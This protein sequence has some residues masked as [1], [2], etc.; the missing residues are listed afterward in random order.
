MTTRGKPPKSIDAD[1]E[2]PRLS[3]AGTLE[4]VEDHLPRTLVSPRAYERVKKAAAQLPAALSRQIYLECRLAEHSRQVDLIVGVERDGARVLAGHHPS[5]HLAES[6]R[7]IP[8]W[9]RLRGFCREWLTRG[10]TLDAG[11]ER[12]WLEL[13]LDARAGTPEEGTLDPGIFVNFSPDAL[14][15]PPWEHRLEL[16]L[17]SVSRLADEETR[18]VAGALERCF[19]SLPPEASPT[20]VG[21]F[22]A[23]WRRAVRV[24]VRG[25]WG[26]SAADFLES[27]GWPRRRV[28]WV[29]HCLGATAPKDGAQP[30]LLHVEV[31]E[32]PKPALGLEFA[33]S[34]PSQLR[35][36][37]SEQGWLDGL[38]RGHLCAPRK[39]LGLE[40]WPGRSVQT[41]RH[42][43]WPSLVTRWVNHV[44][45]VLA[46]GRPV[47]AKAY[48]Y[49]RHD[50]EPRL[51]RLGS[52]EGSGHSG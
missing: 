6:L 17:E 14:A 47:E 8:T 46:D 28:Q 36:E 30:V 12:V 20:Y 3:L 45:L 24:C 51:S 25:L 10:S 9:S 33:L 52:P 38:V 18:G 32:G 7:R 26:E 16:A 49:L 41:F 2:A 44:K 48:L 29:R 13:D 4:E 35:G 43:L 42:E 37:L 39:R 11:V 1:G 27:L 31:G 15:G 21:I 5:A 19:H 40:R 23:R 22:T 34:R 50:Y